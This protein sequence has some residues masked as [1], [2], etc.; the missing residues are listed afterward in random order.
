[1]QE[2]TEDQHQE[3]TQLGTAMKLAYWRYGRR[4]DR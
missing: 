2:P 1:M 4:L 3:L